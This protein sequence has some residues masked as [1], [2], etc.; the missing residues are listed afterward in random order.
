MGEFA[1]FFGMEGRVGE[2]ERRRE[3]HLRGREHFVMLFGMRGEG[4]YLCLPGSE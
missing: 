2:S 3:R 4:E 1:G